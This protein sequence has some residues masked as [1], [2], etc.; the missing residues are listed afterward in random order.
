[1]TSNSPNLARRWCIECA[2]L[3]G[4]H[5]SR[6]GKGQSQLS[7]F[8]DRT[9]PAYDARHRR[10]ALL[11]LLGN[12]KRHRIS[13][14]PNRQSSFFPV[15]VGRIELP[16]CVAIATCF[17]ARHS[18]SP[19]WRKHHAARTALSS[20][21]L[22][23]RR[24]PIRTHEQTSCRT[25]RACLTLHVIPSL[26]RR[27]YETQHRVR[28]LNVYQ[29]ITSAYVLAKVIGIPPDRQTAEHGKRLGFECASSD[30]R[31]KSVVVG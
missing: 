4:M 18:R 17:E 10:A 14:K 15:P 23:R 25:Q 9:R 20:G 12:D 31:S 27:R 6:S 5:K 16:P 7:R 3:S 13:A 21:A 24:A 1:M 2:D 30:G 26:G 11:R 28:V 22:S 8:E 29:R 19:D